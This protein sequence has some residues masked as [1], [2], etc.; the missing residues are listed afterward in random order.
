MII[1]GW[2]TSTRVAVK[3]APLKIQQ[4]LRTWDDGTMV[5]RNIQGKVLKLQLLRVLCIL[6]TF[7]I[8]DAPFMISKCK[9]NIATKISE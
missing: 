4:K 3:M 9:R 5:D 7:I 6:T 2:P 8:F 1:K